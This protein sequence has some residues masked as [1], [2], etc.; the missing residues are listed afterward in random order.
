M[1]AGLLVELRSSF[2]ATSLTRA[3]IGDEFSGGFSLLEGK[4]ARVRKSGAGSIQ[5]WPRSV[6]M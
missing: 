2:W 5:N 1:A 4:A 6:Q 3:E